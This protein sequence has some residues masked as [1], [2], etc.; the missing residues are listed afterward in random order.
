MEFFP[1][2]IFY[3]PLDVLFVDLSS[4]DFVLTMGFKAMIS[5]LDCGYNS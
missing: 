5:L 4:K 3:L 2:K 1:K